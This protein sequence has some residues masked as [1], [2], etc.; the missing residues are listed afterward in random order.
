MVSQLAPD[1]PREVC[2]QKF[3]LPIS[4]NS[5]FITL[6][7]TE[8]VGWIWAVFFCFLAGE[9]ATFIRYTKTYRVSQ[10]DIVYRKIAKPLTMSNFGQK[11]KFAPFFWGAISSI[12]NQGQTRLEAT[13]GPRGASQPL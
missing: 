3:N 10:N 7:E 5:T 13:G 11:K 4:G 2:S 8:R 1:V 9:L 12:L 6:T